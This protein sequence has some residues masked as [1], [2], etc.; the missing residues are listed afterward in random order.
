MRGMKEL[1]IPLPERKELVRETNGCIQYFLSR[2]TSLGYAIDDAK[3]RGITCNEAY[4]TIRERI[5]KDTKTIILERPP[6]G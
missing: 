2:H 6:F 3:K 1:E 4:N 5:E